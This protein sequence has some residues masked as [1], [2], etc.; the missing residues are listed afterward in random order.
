MKKKYYLFA[1]AFTGLV[2]TSCGGNGSV[3]LN[4]DES[5]LD[6]DTEWV[7]YS[8]PITK[9][10]FES[11]EKSISIPR[12]ETHEYQYS[13]EPAKAVKAA[14]SWSSSDET[15][16]TVSK[17]VVSALE[18]GKTTITCFNKEGSFDPIS[19]SVEVIVPVTDIRFAQETLLADFNHQY[20]LDTLVRYEP[21]D[22]TEIGLSW[23]SSN[24]EVATVS[25]D[26]ILTTKDVTSSVTITA[27]SE[28]IN[29]IIELTV[30]VADRTIYPDTVN[31]TEFESEVEIGHNFTMKAEAVRAAD[32][33][34][35][36]THPEVK[37]YSSDSTI[38]TV[39]EDTGVV[40]AL[41]TGSANIYATAQGK[42]GLVTSESKTV[43][44]FEVKVQSIILED[45]ELTNRNG[46]S[47]IEIPM[48][49]TTDKAGYEKASIPNFVYTV[50]DP[51]VATV[52]NGKLYAV[53]ATGSTTLNVT[54]TRSNASKTVNLT[55]GYEVDSISV[56]GLTEVTI[57]NSITL[58][59]TSD[60]AGVPKELF[61][62]S[63]SDENIATVT[64]NGV[65]TGVSAGEVEITVS[66]FGCEEV[67]AI[68]VKNPLPQSQFYVEGIGGVWEVD[69]RYALKQDLGDS[70]HFY[71]GPIFLAANTQIKVYD[72]VNDTWYGSSEGYTE[73]GAYWKTTSEGNLLVL[74]EGEFY[75]D[76]YIDAMNDNHIKLYYNG[77]EDDP[78]YSHRYYAEGIGGVWKAEEQYGMNEDSTD[79]NHFYL[80]PLTL[81]AN[82]EIKIYDVVNDKWFGSTQGYTEQ[83]AYWTTTSEGNLKTLVEGSFYID[84]YLDALND[85]HIKLYYDNGEAPGEDVPAE[86]GYYLVGSYTN[87]K[88]EGATKM[89]AG[90][91]T[92]LAKLEGFAVSEG[93]EFKVRG[94]HNEVESWHN[95]AEHG[96][97]N[98]VVGENVE[99]IDVYLSA[100]GVFY[101]VEHNGST[102]S[103]DVPAEEGYYIVGSKTNY[104][105]EGATKMGAGEGTD[106]AKLEGY[107]PV[108]GEEFKVRGY[109]A[110]TSTWYNY[111]NAAEGHEDDN[112]VVGEDVE[113]LDVY[114]N[115]EGKFY[116]VEHKSVTPSEDVPAE[117]GYYLVGSK[118][119]WK[120]E[121]ATKMSAGEGTD[122]AKLEGYVPV[123]GEEFRVRGYHSSADTWYNWGDAAEG[124]EDDNYVVGE[125]VESLDVYL[126]SEG[127]FYVVE[128]KTGPEPTTEKVFYFTLPNSEGGNS[129]STLRAYVWNDT[130]K[131]NM[132]EWPGCEMSYAGV[133]EYNQPVYSI[134]IDTSK[135]DMIIFNSGSY[136][137]R[138]I[139]LSEFGTNNAC[140]VSQNAYTNHA[141]VG[142]W[143]K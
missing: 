139:A 60:P 10:S 64:N 68:S 106:L 101:I 33:E 54:E 46:R 39:E 61:S 134:T 90:E 37:Y 36:V 123:E 93:Q 15:V 132:G 87:W 103:E 88:F 108:E 73:Q 133:N 7:E 49:Y 136:Q 113:T 31:V 30:E 51:E 140:Y 67:Y 142:F 84:L 141:E 129:W 79:P 9:V 91:G 82:T 38:L 25:D 104:K 98:Y 71:L 126:N 120:Y 75:V 95:W 57:G 63:S 41:A 16:A 102:P 89:E 86:D 124:H 56:I 66:A 105:F 52:S 21:S 96:E 138:D 44:V 26:G 20:H 143:N 17:G 127:K 107:V 74:I 83:G 5:D 97:A 99:T 76:L 130:S 78:V 19:L 77:T 131:A 4:Y 27:S 121:G 118:T 72:Y 80:G 53:A 100:A 22:T 1:L 115:S 70:N 112:Y 92:D 94:Y 13:I 47:D 28:R 2:L 12:G 6:I 122:L 59:A 18:V 62:Y 32:P 45:I 23:H 29:K 125:D 111:G 48:T 14:L 109:H 55:V 116:V 40:H 42:E 110:A 3:G 119:S 35:Q 65:V 117:D 50:G 11:G 114:L 135:Y 81:E 137:T 34:V 58:S 8:V 85:N 69:E 128:H 43:T 24:E